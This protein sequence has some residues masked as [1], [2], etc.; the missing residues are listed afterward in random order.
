M[1]QTK[2]LPK[3]DRLNPYGA[4]P[5]FRREVLALHRAIFR[6]NKAR[7]HACVAD[8]SASFRRYERTYAQGVSRRACAPS[9]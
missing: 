8:Y 3:P 7:I 6:A 9:Y 2:K 1:S 5:A 4:A